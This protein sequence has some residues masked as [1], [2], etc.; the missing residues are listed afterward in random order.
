M[1]EGIKSF[2]QTSMSADADDDHVRKRDMRLA[3][4]ALL[5]ELAYADDEFT[6]DEFQHLQGAI[7]RQYGL[8]HAQ[9]D[10]LIRLAERARAEA[11]D[12]WQFTRLIKENY[13]LGQKMVL[14]EIMWGLVYSDGELSDREAYLMRKVCKLLDLEPG[15]LSEAEK[16]VK[17]GEEEPEDRALDAID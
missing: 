16:R 8:D 12:L 15:Y 17:G 13:S 6:E 11:H 7:R 3:A 5:L 2:F 10:R 9:A 1:L 14:A 4:C